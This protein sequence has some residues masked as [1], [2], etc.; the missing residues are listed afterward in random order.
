MVDTLTTVLVESGELGALLMSF[1]DETEA[2]P[3]EIICLVLT[4]WHPD[5]TRLRDVIPDWD[6]RERVLSLRFTYANAHVPVPISETLEPVICNGEI[7]AYGLRKATAG[8]WA[9]A[10]SLNVEGL[11]HC[12]L[13]F[14]GVP[15]PAPWESQIIVV[16]R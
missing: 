4:P 15:N 12:Y 9:L 11:V 6:H 5:I 13:V 7:Q 1:M 16:S 8:V 2:D 10:P 14:H 3:A